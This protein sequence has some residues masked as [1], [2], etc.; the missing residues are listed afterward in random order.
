MPK[1]WKKQDMDNMS[2]YRTEF[3]ALRPVLPG[4][5]A[6]M[7]LREKAL[8][9][10]ENEGLPSRHLEE[11]RYTDASRILGRRKLPS[12]KPFLTF[13][14]RL[15]KRGLQL[16]F[17][18]GILQKNSSDKI[19]I[20]GLYI[21]SL[22]E[23]LIQNCEE[24]KSKINEPN[25]NSLAALNLA[26]TQDGIGL[27]LQEG[28]ELH[29]PIE[30]V[31]FETGKQAAHPRNLIHIGAG[32]KIEIIE[33]HLGAG[34]HNAVNKIIM[35]EAAELAHVKI[36]EG[37]ENHYHFS[38]T[39]TQIAEKAKYDVRLLG[40]GGKVSR[41]EYDCHLMGEH[42]SIDI[43]SAMLIGKGQHMDLTARILHKAPNCKSNL[44]A[45]NIIGEKGRGVFQGSVFVEKGAKGSE[46]EQKQTA[47]LL[48]ELAEMNAKPELEI[49]ADE[50][51]C[52]HGST[53][54][55]LSEEGLFYLRSRGL[56]EYE[57]KSLLIKG[58]LN[59]AF[60]AL[61]SPCLREACEEK[62]THKLSEMMGEA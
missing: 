43:S 53:I 11:W 2:E 22:N 34:L 40:L 20:N 49:Y 45:R 12:Q 6:I 16:I 3:E 59:E 19:N 26:L 9:R 56:P 27:F 18:D 17:I 5:E 28:I 14:D 58:I 54:G 8:S 52:A 32:A 38:F 23:V 41:D 36:Y 60:A 30:L 61:P 55:G 29:E 35:D 39:R 37:S 15:P 62:I 48:H 47:I 42:A 44:A 33:T 57:A 50:V 21:K 51:I 31:F 46:A 1:N 13:P 7:A 4:G 10:L 25:V 24:T